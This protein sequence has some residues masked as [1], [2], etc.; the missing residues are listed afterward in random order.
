MEKNNTKNSG[1]NFSR[2]IF[3]GV[4]DEDGSGFYPGVELLNLVYGNEPNQ[5]LPSEDKI[6]VKRKAHDFA[7]RLVWDEDFTNKEQKEKVLFDIETE[8]AISKLLSC[9]QLPIPSLTKPPTWSRAHFFPSTKSLIHWD[10]KFK[11]KKMKDIKMERIYLRGG[12]AL[13]FHV[14]RKDKNEQR[15]QRSRIG[16]HE[17]YEESDQSALEILASTLLEHS[18]EDDS[19]SYDEIESKS[20]LKNDDDEELYRDGILNI[21]EHKELAAV[22]RIR[23][24][25][26]WTAF[27]LVLIQHTRASKYIG[28]ETSHIICDCG[29]QQVQLR[30]ASQRCLKNI[31]SNILDAVEKASTTEELSK[32][33]KDKIKNFFWSTSSTIKLLNSR[34]GR[35][36]FTLGLELI[37]TLVLASTSKNSE[38][39]YSYFVDSWLYE[40]CKL[41]IGRRAAESTGQLEQFDACVF[42]DN[43]KH[44]AIQM[45]AAGFLNE[46]SDATQMVG[47]GGL[48]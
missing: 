29:A 34:K 24:V 27:W 16:F 28:N 33:Q 20:Y 23:A 10:A 15:L 14:L 6:Y 41:I 31:Q 38:I 22:V 5:L 19:A 44:L 37:E 35:K 3:A 47:T 40:K 17:L 18:K 36:H 1:T 48:L 42:E 25:I 9:L 39:P 8:S 45:K 4:L 32:K 12:G 21:L 11:S 30:K 26:N 13:A 46:Y 2:L 43:A 7:R